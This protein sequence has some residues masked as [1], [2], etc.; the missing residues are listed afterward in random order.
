MEVTGQA[1]MKEEIGTLYRIEVTGQAGLMSQVG[2]C[3]KR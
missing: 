1:G 2:I 3:W